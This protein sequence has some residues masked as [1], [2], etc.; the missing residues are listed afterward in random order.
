ML[1]R[2]REL[3]N[4][5]NK[6]QVMLCFKGGLNEKL[7]GVL[8]GMVERKMESFEPSAKI[9][10]RV[11]QV[12]TECMQNLNRHSIEHDERSSG[13]D[14]IVVVSKKENG[15]SVF[16]GNYMCNE[17]VDR[18]RDQLEEINELDADEL[19][20]LYRQVLDNGTYTTK[21]GGGLG[22][23]DMA[24]KSNRKL[25]YAFVPMDGSN[26]FFSLNVN[27]GEEN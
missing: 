4:D 22:I 7:I 26:A 5:L 10:K 9:R 3:Y 18:L 20:S 27:V 11:F 24:R 23:I 17:E 21:G 19:K 1:E 2:I 15:Y 14:G 25:E 8:L 16:T 6:E 13:G 12:L